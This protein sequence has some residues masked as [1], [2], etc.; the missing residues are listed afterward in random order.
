MASC[1]PPQSFPSLGEAGL[2]LVP[3]AAQAVG[4]RGGLSYGGALGLPGGGDL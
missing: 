1:A 4:L 2:R 3:G